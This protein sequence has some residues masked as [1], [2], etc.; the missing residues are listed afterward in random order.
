VLPFRNRPRVDRDRILVRHQ[1]NRLERGCSEGGMAL[2][3]CVGDEQAKLLRLFDLQSRKDTWERALEVV[4]E[5][6]KLVEAGIGIGRPIV[7][8]CFGALCTRSTPGKRRYRKE[9]IS[10]PSSPSIA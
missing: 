7:V 2:F 1:H 3:A 6:G 9:L 10:C 5:G 8:E 4:V